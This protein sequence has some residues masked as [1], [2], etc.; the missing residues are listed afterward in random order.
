MTTM[1][2]AI[3]PATFN[4]DETMSTLRYAD[5][6]KSIK[7]AA[8]INETPQ[9]KLIR[10]LKEENERLKAMIEGKYVQASPGAEV[11]RM[12]EETK[13]EYEKQIEELRKA[14]EEAEKTWQDR[15]RDHGSKPRIVAPVQQ[16]PEKITKPHFSNLNEDPLLSGYIKHQF[17]PGR[18]VIG[19]KNPG[20]PPDIII[21]GLGVGIDHCVVV[22]ENDEY[23]IIP[24]QDP[25]LKTMLNG[26]ILTEETLL[27][28][29]DRIRFGNHNYF[30][31]IDP[32]ELG[33]TPF[34]WE[35]AVNEANEEQVKVLLGHQDEEIKAKEEEMRKKLEAEWE[36][37]RKKMDEERMQLEKLI[38]S[39]K[40]E[41]SATQKA[42]ADKEAELKARQRAME[43]EIREKEIK[44]KQHEEE[45]NALERLK[46]MLTNAIQQINEANERAVVLGKNALFQP[47]LYR[48]ADPGR[49]GV[50]TG[51]TS[52]KVRI[53]VTYPGLSDDFQIKWPLEKLEARLVDMQEICNQLSLGAEPSEIDIG[54]DPFSDKLDSLGDTYRLIGY[55]YVYLDVIYHLL[56]LDEDFIPIIDDRGSRRGSLKVAVEPGLEGASTSD[57]DN[58]KEL[59]GK[60]LNLTISISEAVDV[61]DAFSTGIFCK[62]RLDMVSEEE[63]S[64][65]KC[66]E[67]TTN[68]HFNYLKT[69]NIDLTTEIAE[70]F[71]NHALAIAVHGDITQEMKQRELN[72][73][74]ANVNKAIVKTGINLNPGMANLDIEEELGADLFNPKSPQELSKMVSS[75]GKSSAL[76]DELMRKEEEIRILKAELAKRS[77]GEVII[78][79][80]ADSPP[81][82]KVQTVKRGSCAC[83]IF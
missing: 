6:V 33:G 3:S 25:N 39:K 26:K 30:L 13:K 7:N 67:T 17:K 75:P 14:K 29:Q 45:R 73:L 78:V 82:V 40:N 15:L 46:K 53:R 18:N 38:K 11:I 27:N 81:V 56:S 54:Y 37:A 72:K 36:E 68:P 57:F 22:Y 49:T 21:E 42:L 65:E 35:K 51:L 2:A 44:M 48:E 50:G 20:S 71:L 55:A 41:D 62:Y 61:P 64:T 19:K 16:E 47:E 9:E 69:H 43:E 83:L 34:D 74:K 66:M 10:E 5:A 63:F 32:D 1:I 8:V 60:Q 70:K 12:D 31:F 77:G 79:N 59:A 24:S 23:K 58:L 28:H 4:Y 52:T 80:Q 76:E